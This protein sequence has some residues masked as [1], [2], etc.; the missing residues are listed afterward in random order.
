MHYSN[1]NE[2]YIE[3]QWKMKKERII[4]SGDENEQDKKCR[5]D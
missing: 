5:K 1:R 4:C 3:A 2:Q